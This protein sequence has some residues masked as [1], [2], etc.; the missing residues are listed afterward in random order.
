MDAIQIL[1]IGKDI[2]SSEDVAEGL[3]NSM[4]YES[5]VF[6]LS[7]T[8]SE[9]LYSIS[10]DGRSMEQVKKY[11]KVGGA[12]TSV[13][14]FNGLESLNLE[15]FSKRVIDVQGAEAEIE[16]KKLSEVVVY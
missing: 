5:G 9:I 4:I 12:T 14:Y 6:R 8:D 7:S 2:I 3:Y 11:N 1:N 13:F 15:E 10:E 16:W